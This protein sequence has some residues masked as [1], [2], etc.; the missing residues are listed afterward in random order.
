MESP[1]LTNSSIVIIGGTTGLGLSAA[2]SLIQSG[3]NVV[4]VGRKPESAE[5]ALAELR[6]LAPGQADAYTGDAIDSDT[7]PHAIELC[8][9]KFGTFDGIYHVAGGSGRAFGDGPLHEVTDEGISRTLDLNLKSLI[10]S[11]RA[12]VQSFLERKVPGSILNMGSVLGYSPSP[13]YFS[14]HIYAAAKS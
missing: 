14:T 6:A 8:L 7:A 11:N 3:A 12:A 9:G 2:K 10:L 4:V 5:K 13:R 1:I